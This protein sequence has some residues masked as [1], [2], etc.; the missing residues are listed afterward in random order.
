VAQ[1]GSP[2]IGVR[3]RASELESE[4]R[5]NRSPGLAVTQPCRA[6]PAIENAMRFASGEQ[7]GQDSWSR[8]GGD[9]ALA[10]H[11][12][13]GEG[14]QGRQ[15]FTVGDDLRVAACSRMSLYSFGLPQPNRGWNRCTLLRRS[16]RFLHKRGGPQENGRALATPQQEVC[17]FQRLKQ[18]P[19]VIMTFPPS[20]NEVSAD[21]PPN[22]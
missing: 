19:F 5:R 11:A 3:M 6:V 22:H 21:A 10:G 14:E 1:N 18:P 8:T 9:T 15:V 12:E 13:A 16:W 17:V 7:N 2:G 20:A 4:K